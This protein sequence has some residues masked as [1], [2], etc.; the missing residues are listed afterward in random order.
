[1]P[2][3]FHR[4]D[5]SLIEL[6]PTYPSSM[7]M[8]GKFVIDYPDHF[9]IEAINGGS[10]T[11]SEIET[12][13]S[14]VLKEK[15][16]AF[17]HFIS[18]NFTSDADFADNFETSSD[19][20]VSILDSNFFPV[21]ANNQQFTFN[22]SFKRGPEPNTVSVLGRFPRK[23]HIEGSTITSDISASGNKCIITKDIEI[24]SSTVDNL[25]RSDFFLYF[26]S[27]LQS[28]VKD[29]SLSDKEK[30]TQS[31]LTANRTG[32]MSY[33]NTQYDSSNRLRCFISSDD[34]NTYREIENLKVFSFNGRVDTI[35]LA[36]VNTTDADLSLLS[37]TLMY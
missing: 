21:G 27:A 36:W 32:Y 13:V 34:G 1:M 4:K 22:V 26:R 33:T 17:D 14:N 8:S 5:H 2:A 12:Q 30:N 31:P 25:G 20:T 11:V 6:L 29:R 35:K 10:T 7:P 3:V 18:N 37:Y 24:A 9:T 23:N 28:Y 16:V 15:F 19:K